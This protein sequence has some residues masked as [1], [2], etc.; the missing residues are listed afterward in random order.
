MKEISPNS[1]IQVYT[2][3]SCNTKKRIGAWASIILV[4]NEE[5]VLSGKEFDTTNNRMELLAVIKSVNYIIKNYKFDK[6]EVFSDSQYV[7]N[8]TN[9]KEKL[10]GNEFITKKGNVL[11][12]S[13][14]LKELILLQENYNIEFVKVKAHQKQVNITNYNIFVDKLSRKIVRNYLTENNADCK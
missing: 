12:N 14:L 5:I 2:D 3:G 4:E 10:T 11:N 9:R 6:I 8:I 7:V 13:D 1:T